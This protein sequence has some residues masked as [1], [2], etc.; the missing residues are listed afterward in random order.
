MFYLSG[1]VPAVFKR[2]VKR[3][4]E[5]LE[6]KLIIIYKPIKEI[7]EGLA[8]PTY[9]KNGYL[10]RPFES[11]VKL[12]GIPSYNELDPT[13]F[14]GISY[15]LLFGAMFGD[16]GQGLVL[17]L[18]GEFLNRRKRRPN[19]GGVLARLGISSTFLVLSME[20]YLDL[21]MFLKRM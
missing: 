10:L 3:S 6:E 8:P 9:L 12:Y 21:K 17:F 13:S 1:W 20:V 11:I 4:L 18:I 19:L 16:V 5:D 7:R 14:V 15:M 2:R